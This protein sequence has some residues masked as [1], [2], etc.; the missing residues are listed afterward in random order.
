MKART[1]ALLVPL[2]L[3]L[4]AG[5][6]AAEASAA[7][8]GLDRGFGH[9]GTTRVAVARYAEPNGFA[10]T[11]GG[12]SYVLAGTTLLAFRS[13]GRP[14]RGF[15]SKGR[16]AV[17]PPY[18]GPYLSLALDSQGRP[19]VAGSVKRSGAFEAFVIRF[20]PDGRRDPSFGSGGEV[21]TDLGLPAT[22]SG[23]R[24]NLRV[25]SIAV[26]AQ[27]RPLIGGGSAERL[28][29]CESGFGGP[30]IPFVA[31]LTAAGAPDTTFAGTGYVTLAEERAQVTTVALKPDGGPGLLSQGCPTEPRLEG[32]GSAYYAFS[33]SGEAAALDPTRGAA[34]RLPSLAIDPSGRILLVDEV[35]PAAEGPDA[36]ARFLPNGELDP[37]F[38]RGGKVVLNHGLHWASALT[39]DAAGRPIIAEVGRAIELRRFLSDGRIDPG[40]GPGGRL[41]V[42]GPIV[43]AIALDGE[44]RIYTVGS[45]RG[46]GLKTGYG[47]AI[48]RLLPG[49]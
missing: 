42:P 30:S 24:P 22:P 15:G 16:V 40:F 6:A 35:G 2:L 31:R 26:D 36:L 12:R 43:Q 37:G 45:I 47:I 21:D 32:Q 23:K 10:V 29:S 44:G 33:E 38:G 17:V 25:N 11:P 27:D 34:Y 3:A 48:A 1:A 4:W 39:V 19:L 41:T 13:D 5:T 49:S 20:L 14:A 8:T 28:D 9:A 18:E 46:P 7:D